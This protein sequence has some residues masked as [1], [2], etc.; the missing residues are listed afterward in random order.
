MRLAG[1]VAHIEERIGFWFGNLGE[2][3]HLETMAY[4]YM[5]E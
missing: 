4:T 1:H 2:R 3:D 5:G